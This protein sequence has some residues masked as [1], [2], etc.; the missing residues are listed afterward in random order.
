M[1]P[2]DP[3]NAPS[4]VYSLKEQRELLRPYRRALSDAQQA[5]RSQE[6][7][8]ALKQ[9]DVA[10]QQLVG[11]PDACV[12]H[13]NREREHSKLRCGIIACFIALKKRDVAIAI[14]EQCSN[15]DPA[16]YMP[17]ARLLEALACNWS[18]DIDASKVADPEKAKVRKALRKL[19]A[20][21]LQDS[22]HR[23]G[24]LQVSISDLYQSEPVRTCMRV[25]Q[26][27]KTEEGKDMLRLLIRELKPDELGSDYGLNADG[28]DAADE[29]DPHFT[30]VG[31]RCMLHSH[32]ALRSAPRSADNIT[33]CLELHRK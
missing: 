5:L 17:H 9:F 6:W 24:Q 25:A 8:Q 19:H 26:W 29:W 10:K 11:L 32:G 1:P 27:H 2:G 23:R 13:G 16:W 15:D 33:D 30:W 18:S 28:V 14:A 4:A 20:L 31:I 12:P 3:A 7:H 22:G 21:L